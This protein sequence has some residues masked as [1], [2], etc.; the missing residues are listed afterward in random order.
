MQVDP[1]LERGRAHVDAVL[2]AKLHAPQVKAFFDEP[3]LRRATSSALPRPRR[4]R[5]STASG[6]LSAVGTH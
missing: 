5:L 4:L 1:H 6:T 3:T 2:E